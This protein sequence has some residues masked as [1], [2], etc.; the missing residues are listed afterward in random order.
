MVRPPK[1]KL[2]VGHLAHGPKGTESTEHNV[3]PTRR[4]VNAPICEHFIEKRG[5]LDRTIENCHIS[6]LVRYC[7]DIAWMYHCML[8]SNGCVKRNRKERQM[9]IRQTRARLRGCEN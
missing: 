3:G 7:F 5:F 4:P 9:V 6:R 1:T 2:W 8:V